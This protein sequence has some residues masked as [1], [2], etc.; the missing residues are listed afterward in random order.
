MFTLVQALNKEFGD[1]ITILCKN[2]GLHLI[3]QVKWPMKE[4]EL[5]D[6]ACKAGVRV[7]PTSEMWFQGKSL[8]SGAVLM[9]FGSIPLENNPN[10]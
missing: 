4:E 2:A 10:F 3:V 6:K 9:G 1:T 7:Y 5:I 8:D